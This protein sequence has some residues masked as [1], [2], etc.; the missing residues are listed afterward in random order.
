MINLVQT[1]ANLLYGTGVRVNAICPGL[2][3]T[4]M[5]RGDL[6]C[7]PASAAPRTASASSTR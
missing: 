3:E 2:I 7:A 6:S 1:T 5:T 4:G